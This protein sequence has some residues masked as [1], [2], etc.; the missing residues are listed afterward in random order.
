[1]V[2]IFKTG[3]GYLKWTVDPRTVDKCSVEE[4]KTPDDGTDLEETLCNNKAG[5]Y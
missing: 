2:D 4:C 3:K 5:N 1:M